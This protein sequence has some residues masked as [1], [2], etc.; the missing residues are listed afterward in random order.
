VSRLAHNDLS[1]SLV[2]RRYPLLSEVT[3]TLRAAGAT[4]AEMTG[5]GSVLF[6]I[7]DSEPDADALARATGCRVVLTRTALDVEGVRRLD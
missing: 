1:R 2:A 4:I 6:G 7:F 5:S 3:K